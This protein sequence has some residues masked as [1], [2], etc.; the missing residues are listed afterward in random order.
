MRIFDVATD[1]IK[2]GGKRRGA[3]MGV[4]RV[5]HPDI[6]EFIS[7][8]SK[9]GVL[10]N[11]NL[12]VGV[13]DAFMEAVEK[14]EEYELINPHTGEAERKMRAREVFDLIVNMAWRTGDPGL[15]FLDE[16]NRHNP[17]PELGTIEATNPCGEVPLL[18]Y[19]SCNLGSINL[20]KMIKDDEVDWEKLGKTVRAAVHFLDNVIDI[21]KYPLPEI[22]RATIIERVGSPAYSRCGLPLLLAGEIQDPQS[23]LF[24]DREWYRTNG[25][26]LLLNTKAVK[27]LPKERKLVLS[28]EHAGELAYDSLILCT[29]AEPIIPN[30]PGWGCG[31]FSPSGAWMMPCGSLKP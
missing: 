11:F 22:E 6:L 24:A 15:I 31:T 2:Q 25:I 28:G 21:N 12:S 23:L 3:N 8:K 14:D 30:L 17:T 7:A 26:E 19:E 13:T 29:G 18:P 4:L 16:I 20:A 1:V 9:E 5:D 27:I 10:V